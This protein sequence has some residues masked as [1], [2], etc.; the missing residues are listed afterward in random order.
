[1]KRMRMMGLALVAVFAMAIATSSAMAAQPVFY[2]KANVGAVAANVPF[3]ATIG[4]AFLEGAVSKTKITCV[5]V[6]NEKNLTAG[7]AS[8]EVTGA[9]QTKNN[10][11]T[12]TGCETGGLKCNSAGEASGIIK[13][14][15]AAG[16][17]GNVT[18]TLPGIRLFSQSEGKGGKIAEFVCGGIVTVIVKGSVIGSLSGASGTEAANGKF[19]ASDKLTFAEAK[20]IQ[21]YTKFLAGEGEAGTEQLSNNNNG[22][23]FELSGQSVI[24][25]LKSVPAG[26]L[27]ITK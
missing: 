26:N 25:T 16:S 13:T 18:S 24:A 3:T 10:I 1:M 22:G 21:K 19:A 4:A 27:G 11:T 2:T 20:G 6:I 5:D 17:L 7:S 9:T 23:A 14:F 12:F 15:T 8:G